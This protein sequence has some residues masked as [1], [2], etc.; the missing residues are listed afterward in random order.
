M[1]VSSEDLIL[2]ERNFHAILDHSRPHLRR[3][4]RNGVVEG[5]WGGLELESYGDILCAPGLTDI[6]RC[7]EHMENLHNCHV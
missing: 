2:K 7:I 1:K 6:F 4:L 5:G 3:M